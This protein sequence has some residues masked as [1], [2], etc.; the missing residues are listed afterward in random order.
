MF[1]VLLGGAEGSTNTRDDKKERVAERERTVAKGEGSCWV[2][3]DA[4][5]IDSSGFCKSPKNSRALGMTRKA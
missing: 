4:L 1:F 5:S 3:G 2:G